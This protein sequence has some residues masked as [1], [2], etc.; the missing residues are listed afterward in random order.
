MKWQYSYKKDTVVYIQQHT[1]SRW[2]PGERRLWWASIYAS[3]SAR[4]F[5]NASESERGV[6]SSQPGVLRMISSQARRKGEAEIYN[7]GERGALDF[8]L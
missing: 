4:G 8:L 7:Q 1:R 2:A 6:S 3:E 5:I